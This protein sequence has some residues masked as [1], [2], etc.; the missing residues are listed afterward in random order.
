MLEP[1][2]LGSMKNNKLKNF[3]PVYLINLKKDKQRLNVML[4]QFKKYNIKDYYVFEA[5]DGSK[6]DLSQII[7]NFENMLISKS[8]MACTI[9]HLRA[10]EHWLQ[11]SSSEYA[12]F[13]ED[14]LSFETVDFWNWTW[15][16]FLSKINKL[17]DML[18]LSIISYSKVNKSLHLKEK[19]DW[20]TTCYLIKRDRAKK[21]LESTIINNKYYFPI[22]P[23]DAV[24]D[25]ILYA[26]SI[27]YSFPLFVDLDI[28]STIV[29]S[30][31][32]FHQNSR[33]QIID[34]WRGYPK[35][36]IQKIPN[37]NRV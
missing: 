21:L 28:G 3:G 26:N 35:E 15:T 36:I 27:C 25:S 19:F 12:I 31:S 18:Q 1:I 2:Y 5:V 29:D 24:A 10:I 9:S 23:D 17:Y 6:E 4:E 13:M 7:D 34:F 11:T 8:E 32:S 30:R 33:A 14:D 22:S 37:T 16:E 20:S